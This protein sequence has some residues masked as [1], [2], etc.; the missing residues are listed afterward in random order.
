MRVIIA[1]AILS[2]LIPWTASSGTG[3]PYY[4]EIAAKRFHLDPDLLL[5]ICHVESH[6]VPA[7][8]NHDDGTA[9]QKTKGIVSKSY[10]LFQIKLATA[11]GLGF[12]DKEVILIRK[13]K[14]LIKKLVDKTS[15]LLK[16]EINSFYAAKLLR[17]LYNKYGNTL[18]AI[19]AYNAGRY[20][21]HNSKYVDKVVRQYIILKIDQRR[22]A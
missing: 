10:G 2:L 14:K 16:P 13:H 1:L 7:S 3:R 12:V 4:I 15:E 21:K 11:K 8:V 22:H 18:Q 9:D 5:A 19:S 20:V 6:C 17:S